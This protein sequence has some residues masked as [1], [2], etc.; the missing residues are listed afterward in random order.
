MRTLTILGSTGSI[1]TQ[2]LDVVR[3]NPARYRVG[4]LTTNRRGQLL[5]EQIREFSPTGVVA[6]DPVVAQQLRAEFGSQLEVLEGEEGAC[7]VASRPEVD[8][9]V[10]ALV[11]FAGVGPTIAAIQQGKRI[12][13]ANK[14]TLVAAG[15]LITRLLKQHNAELIPVDSEHSA[16]YQC[17]VG[18]SSAEI[19]QLILTASGGPFRELPADQ[20]QH[21]TP[22]Q[23]LRH[24]NWSMGPKI[25]IDS[26]TLMN[27]GLEVMEARWLFD[28]PPE[29]IDVVVHPQSIIHS[30]VQFVDGSVKAQLG[31]PDMRLPIQYALGWPQRIPNE[32]QRMDLPLIGS[33]AFAQPDFQRFPCLGLAFDALR[34]G[35][36]APAILNAANEIAVAQFLDGQ[37]RFTDIPRCI[38]RA[39]ERA[40]IVDSPSLTDILT[41]DART[42]ADVRRENASTK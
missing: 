42:R 26:A 29:N 19:E 37:L 9:V 6:F 10:S 24:P 32:Y 14:E 20:F 39:L 25:T 34:R 35:G 27:K 30:M 22:A 11:G 5:A 3:S 38:E 15:E 40:E 31:L 7:T 23:A 28:V 12:A 13:L 4:Y 33:L 8:I 18:E 2:T 21:I 41:A 36:T 16:I 17:L 1:G